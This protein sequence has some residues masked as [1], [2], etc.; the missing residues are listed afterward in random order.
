[1][2]I[3]SF[4]HDALCELI[5]R[6]PGLVSYL[7][8]RTGYP[9]PLT[10]A[11]LADSHLPADKRKPRPRFSDALVLC[12][13]PRG[14]RPQR[15]IRHRHVSKLAIV[16]E[17]QTSKPSLRQRRRQHGYLA[18]A[19]DFHGCRAV[20]V[21]LTHSRDVAR[22]CAR[23]FWPGQPQ[24]VITMIVFG[25]DNTPRPDAPGA[26]RVAPELAVAGVLNGNLDVSDQED[27]RIVINALQK[28]DSERQ[29]LYTDYVLFAGKLTEDEMM[30][31]DMGFTPLSEYRTEFVRNM[32]GLGLE[33]GRREEAGTLLR[34]VLDSRGWVISPKIATRIASCTDY[35]QLHGWAVRAGTAS[36]LDEIFADL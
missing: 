30:G 3:P 7:L 9:V 11:A 36:S 35:D 6:N 16:A 22:D 8:A 10:P 24:M 29:A 33:Q 13:H 14:R 12:D 17:V 15:R 25:P 19:A 27:R 32:V 4:E 20:L 5:R 1:M 21:G 26:E 18:N 31:V 2:S 23:P 28:A 34:Q